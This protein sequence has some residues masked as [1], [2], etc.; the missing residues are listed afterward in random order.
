M[1]EHRKA[2]EFLDALRERRFP[3]VPSPAI[4]TF[5]GTTGTSG[6]FAT[7][8][9]ARLVELAP[10][11]RPTD[12][13]VR[14]RGALPRPLMPGDNL[15]VSIS[16][17]EQFRGY[18]IKSAPLRARGDEAQAF[19]TLA[20]GEFV[21]HGRQTYTTHHGPY[22]LQFFE[23]I[24]FD[25]VQGTVGRLDHAV[26]AIGPQVNVSPRLVFHHDLQHGRLATYHGD[27]L[28]MKTFRNLTLNR[29]SVRLAFDLDRLEGYAVVGDCAE[30][31]REDHPVA[32]RRVCDGFQ[33]LGFGTPSRLFQHVAERIEPI[34]VAA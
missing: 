31:A 20:P 27:G 12:L 21:V 6:T 33:A 4:L 9:L 2:A 32:W 1:S 24:P 26:V 28:T 23:R 30:L 10:G 7:C 5:L 11:E 3:T 17:Y 13:D 16:R 25:E 18:Q 14:L 29:R 34:A 19:Q 8:A 15:T 22:E